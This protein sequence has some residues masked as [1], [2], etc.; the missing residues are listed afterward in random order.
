V[1]YQEALFRRLTF[2]HFYQKSKLKVR[3]WHDSFSLSKIL[4]SL[5]TIYSNDHFWLI[6]KIR[7]WLF[8]LLRHWN[9][10]PTET[11]SLENRCWSWGHLQ[12]G[13]VAE[14]LKSFMLIFCIYI[15][16]T[17]SCADKWSENPLLIKWWNIRLFCVGILSLLYYCII[18][19]IV[20]EVEWIFHTHE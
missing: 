6:H 9:Y 5:L 12:S 7:L 1:N 20:Q 17:W 14:Y 3:L 18:S 11:H 2:N 10:H 8:M 13:I 19:N 16:K 15:I 4:K